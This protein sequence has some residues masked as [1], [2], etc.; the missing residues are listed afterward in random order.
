M[1]FEEI[2]LSYAINKAWQ[3]QTFA[4]P[5]PSV[6]AL[7]LSEDL[8]VLALEAHCKFGSSHAELQA[9][10]EAFIV[11]NALDAK[12]RKDLD[13]LSPRDLWEFLASNHQ[14]MFHNCSVFVTLEPCIHDGKTPSCAKLLS[15]LKPKKIVFGA[16]D[17]TKK[18]Q[19]GAKFLQSLGIEILGGVCLQESL[20]LLFPF[21][22]YLNKG[23]FNLFKIAQRLNG[24]YKDGQISNVASKIF[25]HNQRG[26]ARSL[27]VSGKTIRTDR[28][29]L[30]TRYADQI[31]N[32][33][34]IQILSRH[35]R[36]ADCLQ[37][38]EFNIVNQVENL[39]LQSGFNIIEGGYPLLSALKEKID[40]LLLFI[41]PFFEGENTAEIEKMEFE[42]LHSAVFDEASRNIALWL[43]PKNLA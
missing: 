11:L 3:V 27:V 28:P 36:N 31:K 39:E 2:F 15:I 37:D 19:G 26:N 17:P 9:F 24:N 10:K 8:K 7:I 5:N 35:Q 25:T 20:N 29:K 23:R 33:P 12:K 16:Y 6:G 43:K 40:A 38:R 18:A 21:L 1:S 4:L 14:G 30:D 13:L 22:T 41:A 32:L 34:K 42:L